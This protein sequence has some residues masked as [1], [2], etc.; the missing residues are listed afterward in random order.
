MKKT[1]QKIR[2]S[3]ATFKNVK[4]KQKQCLPMA[5]MLTNFIILTLII[6]N[7]RKQSHIFVATVSEIA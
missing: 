1:S 5:E 4:I 3:Q 6:D 2:V 7:F